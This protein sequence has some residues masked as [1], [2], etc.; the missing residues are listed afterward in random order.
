[1]ETKTATQMATLYGLK[2]SVAF[3]KLLVKCGVLLH[4]DKGYVLAEHLR[5]RG[6]TVV[7]NAP[8]F[9]PSGIRAFK[10]KSVWNETGQQFVHD[11]LAHHGILPVSER[12]SLFDN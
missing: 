11:I 10:K 1:M 3:N 9:L 5:D 6:L 12:T 2:S 4:T 7:I 8:F